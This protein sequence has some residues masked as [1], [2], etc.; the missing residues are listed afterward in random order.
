MKAQILQTEARSKRI[1]IRVPY[2]A[3]QWRQQLKTIQGIWYHKEQQLWSV[4]N[5]EKNLNQL[6]A[7]FGDNYIIVASSLKPSNPAFEMSTIVADR[8]QSATTKMILA[9]LSASTVKLYRGALLRY[10]HHY[11]YR[12]M[13]E[14]NK[15]EIELYMYDLIKQYQISNAKQNGIINAIKYYHEKVLGQPRTIYNLTRPKKS[16]TL[17]EVLS[18]QEVL[19]IINAPKNA[20]HRAMLYIMYSAGLRIG[21]IPKLRIE[22]I[23][24]KNKQIFVKAAKGKKDR[25]T[26]LSDTTLNLL[27]EYYKQYKPSYWLFEGQHGGKYSTSSITKVFRK[28]VLASGA[29]EWATPHTLRHSFATHLL[30]AQV[31][32]RYIQTLLGHASPKTTQIYTHVANINNDTVRSPLDRMMDKMKNR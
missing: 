13:N 29:N 6:K 11:Q 31:N 9:G 3:K 22:D 7:A 18:E 12:E 20:K 27:R 19:A 23:D 28:A 5:L 10:L 21:E 16:K 30:Q 14:V 26:I 17:P 24:S 4:P 25:Y 2:Q 1:K 15:E 32:L 8:I